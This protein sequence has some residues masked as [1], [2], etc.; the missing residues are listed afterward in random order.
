MLRHPASA[1]AGPSPF[2]AR[3]LSLTRKLRRGDGCIASDACVVPN[4]VSLT[5]LQPRAIPCERWVF[6]VNERLRDAATLIRTLRYECCVS[7]LGRACRGSRYLHP[8]H[9]HHR[10]ACRRA[11]RGRPVQRRSLGRHHRGSHQRAAALSRARRGPRHL[12]SGRRRPRRTPVGGALHHLR[13]ARQA[14]LGAAARHRARRARTGPRVTKA[15]RRAI[16]WARPR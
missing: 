6:M 9:S 15:A 16:R 14:G 3:A 1:T 7:G 2:E 5:I 10:H 12:L 13:Q 4:Q 11:R 8:L